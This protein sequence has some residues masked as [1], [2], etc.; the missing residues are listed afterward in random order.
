MTLSDFDPRLLDSYA[1]PKHLLHFEWQ[2]SSDV[3]RYALVEIIKSN[4]INSR[5]KQKQDEQG[6]SQEEI[7]QKYNIV[8][9][10]D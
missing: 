9:K 6:L 4:K 3:Y 1:K 10:K 8:V 5:N 7:W 2:K